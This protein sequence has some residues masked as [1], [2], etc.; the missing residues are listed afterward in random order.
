MN[1][2]CEMNKKRQKCKIY[3]E[4][5]NYNNLQKRLYLN[6]TFSIPWKAKY[7]AQKKFIL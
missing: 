1:K 4:K 6:Y 5:M 2:K 7:V 3:Q